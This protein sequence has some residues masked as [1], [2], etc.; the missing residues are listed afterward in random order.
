MRR[1]IVLLAVGV[2]ALGLFLWLRVP[3]ER[4]PAPVV[5]GPAPDAPRGREPAPPAPDG[6]DGADAVADPTAREVVVRV[7]V[8]GTGE[9]V[10]GADVEIGGRRGRTGADGTVRLNLVPTCVDFGR[11]RYSYGSALPAG[12]GCRGFLPLRGA[13][14]VPLEG[15]IV[16]F[17]TP[18]VGAVSGVVLSP[19]G[20]PLA[21]AVVDRRGEEC[22]TG[23]DGRFGPIPVGSGE[24]ELVVRHPL[25]ASIRDFFRVAS[26]AG[27]VWREIVLAAP[28]FAR[29]RIV[30]GSGAPLAGVRVFSD[31]RV[32]DPGPGR[33]PL[34]TTD[35]EGRFR[36]PLLAGETV[37]VGLLAP[38]YADPAR[39]HEMTA[40]EEAEIR[41]WRAVA[42]GGRILAADGVGVPGVLLS[43]THE[44]G[45]YGVGARTGPN[46]E[47]RLGPLRAGR[48]LVQA[49][50]G[51]TWIA[52]WEVEVPEGGLATGAVLRL[53][54]S[55]EMTG[56]VLDESDDRPLAGATVRLA[57]APPDRFATRTGP[58]GRFRLDLPIEERYRHAWCRVDAAGHLPRTERLSLRPLARNEVRL[59]PAGSV[60]LRALDG[61]G[62]PIAEALVRFGA[63][64]E[65]QDGYT[66]AEGRAEFLVPAGETRVVVA[67]G[68]A[69]EERVV[70]PAGGEEV[71]LGDLRL[72][73]PRPGVDVVLLDP[74]GRPLENARVYRSGERLYVTAPG[75]EN[76]GYRPGETIVLRRTGAIAGRVVD[77][78]GEPV[79]RAAV[80]T[81]APG[82]WAETDGRGR[83][84][85]DG[86]LPDELHRVGVEESAGH[87]RSPLAFARAGDEAIELVSPR[88]A[89]LSVAVPPD[90][91]EVSILVHLPALLDEDERRPCSW[92]DTASPDEDGRA[93]FTVPAGRLLVEIELPRRPPLLCEV[94]TK[95]GAVAELDARVLRPSSLGGLVLEDSGRPVPDAEVSAILLSGA[96]FVAK[97][98]EAG[99][100]RTVDDRGMP[101]GRVRLLVEKEGFAPA[102]TEPVDLAAGASVTVRLAPGGTISGCVFL[103]GAPAPDVDVR[104]L[105]PLR[106][107]HGG[108]EFTDAD[109]RFTLSDRVPAGPARIE[110]RAP[111]R[112]PVLRDLQVQD[113]EAT[114]LSIDLP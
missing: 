18:A 62:R 15:E 59:V 25:F 39:R 55:R 13:R 48:Q 66:D 111:G 17:L 94:E 70:S 19:E 46:G 100:I 98:D 107:A 79:A 85:I 78:R 1:A 12:A 89:V 3:S 77:E 106:E 7:L 113:G 103:A 38:G 47:F 37:E 44:S 101:R 27:P 61:S 67:G 104:L 31:A 8:D 87:L 10:A 23:A 86:V 114:E 40:G 49:S 64:E 99:R 14:D 65:A 22:R 84:R 45:G 21:G 80:R 63:G 72:V 71:D 76:R 41:L 43:A 4:A 105:R 75:F 9:P 82:E 42:F 93:R 110:I 2:F 58:D 68:D 54:P 102:V 11:G 28:V 95:A 52:H 83:F 69:V 50:F 29:G 35:R 112:L 91:E 60:R 53:P 90:A 56:V 33:T 5:P 51:V 96:R 24:D 88:E 57:S 32:V 74:E 16:F 108:W 36:L 92:R 73:A 109:G 81:D 97:T 30:D 26:G 6:A 34:A 20:N